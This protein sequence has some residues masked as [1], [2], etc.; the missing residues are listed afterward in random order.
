MKLALYETDG[1][2]QDRTLIGEDVLR[3]AGIIMM[4]A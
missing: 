1:F 2:H 4:P 3:E